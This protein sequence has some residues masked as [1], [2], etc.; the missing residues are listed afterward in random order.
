MT[1]FV[2]QNH[3]PEEYDEM[4]VD[5]CIIIKINTTIFRTS[6]LHYTCVTIGVWVPRI[7]GEL[8]ENVLK[9]FFFCL[10]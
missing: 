1:Q 5:S 4:E 6:V 10:F 8:Q 9:I 3:K 7:G 2:F